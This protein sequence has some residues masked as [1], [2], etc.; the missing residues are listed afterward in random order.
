MKKWYFISALFVFS[1]FSC[2]EKKEFSKLEELTKYINSKESG[3]L[4][5][6]VVGGIRYKIKYLPTD[7]LIYKQIDQQQVP[8]N[9][10][11]DSLYSAFGNSITFLFSIGPESDNGTNITNYGVG[12]YEEF[13]ERL[14]Q[15]CFD[16]QEW[17]YLQSSSGKEYKPSLV[18]LENINSL[19]KH[20]NLIVVFE[21]DKFVTDD[22][23]FVFHDEIFQTGINKF[24]FKSND[25][26]RIPKIKLEHDA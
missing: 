18:H 19:E 8:R 14:K 17:I 7:Y 5:E 21:K 13:S 9:Y 20:R 1:L 25:I 15:L 23:S 26:K 2:S 3:L 22:F 12:N 6:K 10:A 24:Y 4:N 11:I 16:S